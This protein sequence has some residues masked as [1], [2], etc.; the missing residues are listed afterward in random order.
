MADD[1]QQQ[2][3]V[4]RGINWRETLPFTNI[5]RTFRVAIHPSKLLLALVAL[6]MLY[7]GGHL[8]DWAWRN[9]HLP[10]ASEF[11]EFDST[12]EG[13]MAFVGY[14]I[15]QVNK[16]AL[17]VMGGTWLGPGSVSWAVRDFVITGP[18]TLARNHPWYGLV[19]GAWFLFI[20]SIFGGAI[21]RIAAVH[22]ARDEKI[23]V[24]QALKFSFAKL[25]SFFF[26]PVIPLL[27][28]IAVGVVLAIGGLLFF[29]P[30]VGPIA[31]GILF[32]LAIVAGFVM[33]LVLL[34]FLGGMN[35]MYPTIAVEGS[36][37][38]DAI[39]RSFS[40]VYARPWRMLFYTAVAV[41]YGALTYL[42][43]RVFIFLMLATTHYFVG[44]WL[45]GEAA[46]HW[47]GRYGI[48][49]IW[50]GP[51]ADGTE[52]T[53]WSLPYNVR[54]DEL[55]WGQD[56]S[57]GVIS[58]WVYLVIGMLGAYAISF[59]FSANTIIYYLIRQE[60]DATELDDVYVEQSEEDF[61]D[62]APTTP[63]AAVQAAQTSSS[64]APAPASDSGSSGGS[65]STS[66]E[67]PAQ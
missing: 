36:D 9:E 4:L 46:D 49:S 40:Y 20:W 5:F 41:L 67:P 52:Q 39:S 29:I 57:A 65:S 2:G 33:T 42:F 34:G 1:A 59:Y 19:Y 16:V 22:V 58:F 37:S 30:Y 23:S 45:G 32:F 61:G 43:V 28:I 31:G 47:Y 24:R 50:P 60:V 10:M 7:V 8:L 27:I 44:W 48:A 11:G 17:A 26:A 15:H 35:L 55:N 25:L 12:N 14:E 64:S 6:L 62:T 66:S 54:Y 38:F 21:C 53:F 13:F 51:T 3:I 63:S 56:I 18:L